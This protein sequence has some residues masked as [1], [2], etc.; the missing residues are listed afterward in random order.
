[1]TF[2][3]RGL[4]IVFRQPRTAEHNIKDFT[5][6]IPDSF[7]CAS[8]LRTFRLQCRAASFDRVCLRLEFT[9]GDELFDNFEQILSDSAEQYWENS[10]DAMGNVAR[11]VARF[12]QCYGV[13]VLRYLHEHA[14]DHMVDYSGSAEVLKSHDTGARHHGERFQTLIRHTNQIPGTVENERKNILFYSF[15][16]R[17]R[18]TFIR[19]DRV[20]ETAQISDIIQFMSNEK[21][22][23]DKEEARRRSVGSN[24][25][26]KLSSGR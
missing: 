23:A 14:R 15:P 16:P 19:S 26:D 3:L 20:Y 8:R 6:G 17:W 22:F 5:F 18:T 12:D 4:P 13:L 21:L 11:T 24:S 1:M 2:I 9:T 7:V 25:G 10:V